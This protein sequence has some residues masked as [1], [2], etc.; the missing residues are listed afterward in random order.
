[1]HSWRYLKTVF[2]QGSSAARKN[3]ERHGGATKYFR[4][5]LTNRT[6][7]KIFADIYLHGKM[8]NFLLICKEMGRLMYVVTCK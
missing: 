3:G 7:H 5:T 2:C 4:L 1:V 6:G 8:R